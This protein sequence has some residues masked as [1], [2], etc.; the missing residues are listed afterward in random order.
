MFGVRIPPWILGYREF[1]QELAWNHVC[2]CIYIYI[3]IYTLIIHTAPQTKKKRAIIK[4]HYQ[5]QQSVSCHFL[6]FVGRSYHYCLVGIISSHLDPRLKPSHL[7]LVSSSNWR[8]LNRST[9]QS[10]GNTSWGS[11]SIF[12]RFQMFNLPNGPNIRKKEKTFNYVYIYIYMYIFISRFIFM[13]I[14]ISILIFNMY[15]IARHV[16]A[17]NWGWDPSLFVFS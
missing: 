4:K 5:R 16:S 11:N 12:Q 1:Q 9:L 3:C 8:A 10:H 6:H 7:A 13:F 17:P 14:F 15:I 2:V